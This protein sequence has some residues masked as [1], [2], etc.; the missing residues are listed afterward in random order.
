MTFVI[1]EEER[2]VT[3]TVGHEWEGGVMVRGAFKLVLWVLCVS[4]GLLLHGGSLSAA[5]VFALCASI[6]S[7]ALYEGLAPSRFAAASS[8]VLAMMAIGL[9]QLYA[10]V[11]LFAFDIASAVMTRIG[12]E[13]RVSMKRHASTFTLRTLWFEYLLIICIITSTFM[14]LGSQHVHGDDSLALRL[15]GLCLVALSFCSGMASSLV[16]NLRR[17][18]LLANDERR[19]LRRRMHH[20]ALVAEDERRSAMHD[21]TLAER[22]RIAREIHD[23]VGHML[24]RGIMQAHT[25]QVISMLAADTQNARS[26]GDVEATFTEAMNAVRSTVH[27]L[28]DEGNDVALQIE[29]ASRTLQGLAQ[30]PR[31]T[32]ENEV[33]QAPA[34]ITRCL[35]MTIRESLN[36]A[37]R[38]SS[39]TQVG[40]VLRDMPALW[41]LVIQ[42]NGAHNP[43]DAAYL[44]VHAHTRWG[45]MRGMGIA[46]IEARAQEF[47]GSALCGPN[48]QGWRVFVSLP[49]E[50]W[51]Q[52]GSADHAEHAGQDHA[53]QVHA[54]SAV[55]E[56]SSGIELVER[57]R[58]GVQ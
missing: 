31:V 51:K 44:A 56:Q 13:G 47:G 5:S 42:D 58:R 41:Q 35:A 24:T 39:A 25:S 15:G 28:D 49:K 4:F 17:R 40:I 16:A 21:A 26:F 32:L 1:S 7:A 34:P 43:S 33:R 55:A 10:F 6:A 57:R 36:N 48:A 3:F 14:L 11:P 54:Q 45:D 12:V 52:Y 27:D 37:V 18:I 2:S 8:A 46:D 50:P 53:E 38:H 20:D 9:P 23:G 29:S 22:T 30:S 19:D